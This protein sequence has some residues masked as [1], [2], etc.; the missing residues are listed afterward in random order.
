MNRKQNRQQ[1]HAGL[2]TLLLLIAATL[3]FSAAG[4]LAES[5]QARPEL[6]SDTGNAS[7]MQQETHTIYL[8]QVSAPKRIAPF[9]FETNPGRM[10]NQQVLS[11]AQELG[12]SWLRLKSVSWREVQATEGAPFDWSV[13][14]TFEDELRAAAQ[15]NLTPIGIVHLNPEWAVMP[16]EDPST[17]ELIYPPCGAIAPEHLNQFATFM[18]ELVARYSKPPYN[19]HYWE[20]GNEPD[21]DPRLLP[22]ELWSY[23]GCWGNWDDPY[24]GGEHYGTMLNTIAPV[25]RQADPDVTIL[26]GGLLLDD[27]ETES[28]HV[29]KPELFLYGMLQAGAGQSFDAVA[30]HA[31]PFYTAID[32]DIDH[33]KWGEWGGVTLGKVAYIRNVLNPYGLQDK[34]LFLTEAALLLWNEGG[35]PPD[36]ELPDYFLDAQADHIVRQL[37]R[38]L[39]V[40]VE[41]YIWYTLHKSGWNASGL[42]NGDYSPR[43]VYTAYQH[44]IDLIGPTQTYLESSGRP[45]VPVKITEYGA[46]VD[47]YRFT[48]TDHSRVIDVVW[49]NDAETHIVSVPT[50]AFQAA[51]SRDGAT[52]QPT[53]GGTVQQIEVS[54]SPLYIV[55]SAP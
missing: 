35:Q 54:F 10:T 49:S 2:T 32:S 41:S 30:F 14:Q 19:V 34:R 40:G 39:A 37:T 6:L 29:G 43:P 33:D 18:S 4:A 7:D 17:G 51:Y 46:M 47:A 11:R 31:Y 36:D 5:R 22:E 15:A 44:Y 25:M 26:T 3:L 50:E 55:R 38:S 23:Y 42:L 16:F 48:D 20:I 21:V 24:Y 1:Q 27:P 9:G 8:P 13:A 53:D 45:V 12:G 52:L 28:D